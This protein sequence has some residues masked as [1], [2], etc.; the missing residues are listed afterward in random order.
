[1]STYTILATPRSFAQ[2]NPLP[3]RLL[4]DAGC[5]VIR[6]HD[7]KELWS[8]LPQADGVIAGLEKYDAAVLETAKKLKV[9]SR[10]GVGYDAIDLDA[11]RKR[12]IRVANTPG[13]NSDSVADLAIGLMLAAARHIPHLDA[14]IKNR[15]E[16]RP[17]GIELWRKTL[18]I[19]GTGRIGKRVM[20]RASGFEMRVLCYDTCRDEAYASSLNGTYT[21]LDTLYTQSDVIS[22]H[23]PLTNET[24]GMISQNEF[25]KMKSTTVIVNTARGGI[26]D[27]KALYEALK[28]GKIFAAG[29]DVTYEEPP[30]ESL[31][32]TLPN[33][34]LTP[35]TGAATVEASHNMGM[36]AVK[37]L[38]E[39]LKTGTCRYLV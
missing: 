29:L 19:L 8:M 34:I 31:L 39:V 1:M 27:E 28:N 21:D 22:I 5:S 14:A 12:G 38:I 4:E 10:Y 11:A 6:P 18:G 9:I 2:Q 17:A 32:C 36:M 35:H 20:K 33:C 30:Y 23:L 26:I 13:A 25:E 24:R 37:N 3:L 16:E 15:A 7:E